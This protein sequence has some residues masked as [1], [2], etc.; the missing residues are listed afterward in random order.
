MSYPAL[1][2]RRLRRS[3]AIRELVAETTIDASDF[4]LPLF[5]RHGTGIKTEISTM[6]GNFHFSTDM[7]LEE[8]RIVRDLGIRGVLLF[9]I[10]DSKD[11]TGSEATEANGIVQQAVRSI[12][13]ALPD[14]L[15]ITDVCLCEY[16][17]HGHCGVVENGRVENDATLELL[18]RQAISHAEAGA[19]IVAPSDMMDGRVGAIRRG[20]DGVGMTEVA[21][22]SYAAK[23]AS[24]FYGPFR[25]AADSAP[26]FGD[27]LGY[28]MDY[29]NPRQAQRE[30]ALD[31]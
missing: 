19:D 6:P 16:T 17:S 26:Q 12:K 18:V 21:I 29:R 4:I 23:F 27:R 3:E 25:E 8:C 11:P 15:V 20:L 30:V 13:E 24:A 5:V 7:L 9:G 31:I 10:P 1:R 22:L 2:M 28:Q 14:L